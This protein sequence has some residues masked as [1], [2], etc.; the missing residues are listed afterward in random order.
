MLGKGMAIAVADASTVGV[1]AMGVGIGV[2]GGV[3]DAV[4][5]GRGEGVGRPVT[6]TTPPESGWTWPFLAVARKVT[7]QVPR[8]SVRLAAHRPSN[9]MPVTSLSVTV[10][11]APRSAHTLV[12]ALPT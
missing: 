5:D 10:P 2:W 6:V 7:A 8:G 9:G 4:G 1:G 11:P 3:G 12:A